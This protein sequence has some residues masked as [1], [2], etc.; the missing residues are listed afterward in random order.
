MVDL[1]KEFKDNNILVVVSGEDYGKTLINVA[2]SS[3]ADFNNIGYVS[4]NKPYN[5]LTDILSKNGIDMNKFNFIDGITKTVTE[6]KPTKN[7]IF[8]S[9]PNALV[10]LNIEITNLCKKNTPDM[11]IFDS[12]S[13]LLV[14]E[15]GNVLLEFVH[16]II[17]V[18]RVHNV[19][20]AF[21]IMKSD[22]N[23]LLK[24]LEMFADKII[25]DA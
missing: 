14:Y 19:K 23:A 12:L 18:L 4:L 1:K 25:K 6:P 15:S 22:L 11:I 16:S 2:K 5:T 13:S 20:G 3:N 17:N 10:E 7:C 9:A 21:I 8:I 24:G